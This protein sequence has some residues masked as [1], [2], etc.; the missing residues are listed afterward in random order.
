MVG[1]ELSLHHPIRWIC[2]NHLLQK[3]KPDQ[4]RWGIQRDLVPKE[5][6][7]DPWAGPEEG[8]LQIRVECL[9]EGIEPGFA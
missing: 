6:P 7:P 9:A 3:P 4:L 2:R 1:L 5:N 8:S